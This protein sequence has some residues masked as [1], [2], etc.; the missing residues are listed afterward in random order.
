MKKVKITYFK[1]TGKYYTSEV[2]EIPSDVNGYD[3][4]TKILPEKHRIK[5][6]F[7]LVENENDEDCIEPY[8]VPTLY[9][10]IEK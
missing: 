3:A 5:D 2:I 1:Q 9:H 10:P 8:I 4:L 7:M 6:M